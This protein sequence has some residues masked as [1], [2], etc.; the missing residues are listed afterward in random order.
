MALGP[1]RARNAR[2]AAAWAGGAARPTLRLS[3]GGGGPASRPAHLTRPVRLPAAVPQPEPPPLPA[4]LPRRQP[5]A[6]AQPAGKP[7][8][9]LAAPRRPELQPPQ[10]LAAPVP[11]KTRSGT[12]HGLSG[13]SVPSP[14][15]K[16]WWELKSVQSLSSRTPAPQP[17]P[18][19]RL[20]AAPPARQAPSPGLA[21][22]PHD[23]A[24]RPS[25]RDVGSRRVGRRAKAA[26]ICLTD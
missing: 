6:A 15:R 5:P 13:S 3:G 17:F 16:A 20:P 4:G 2:T 8:P 25:H 11:S 21:S 1:A 18:G 26:L 22:R 10:G 14:W 19:P 9:A 24:R 7:R 23:P 12:T